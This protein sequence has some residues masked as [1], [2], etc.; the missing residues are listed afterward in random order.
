MVFCLLTLDAT[1]KV[2]SLLAPE[3]GGGRGSRMKPEVGEEQGRGTFVWIQFEFSILR[4][5]LR[6]A[7]QAYSYTSHSGPANLLLGRA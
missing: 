4:Y 6:R 7:Q 1:M 3:E 2:V 5:R